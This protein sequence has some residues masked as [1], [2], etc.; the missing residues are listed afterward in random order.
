MRL[1]LLVRLVGGK[2]LYVTVQSGSYHNR[3]LSNALRS[4][5]N[6]IY[7]LSVFYRQ[8]VWLWTLSKDSA[9]GLAAFE[10]KVLRRIFGRRGGWI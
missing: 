5:G 8:C 4:H 1:K 9:K 6:Y 2:K 7:Q 10:R 3:S